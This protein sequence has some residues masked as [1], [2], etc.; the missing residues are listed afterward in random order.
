[1]TL[2]SRR[3]V[4]PPNR[5]GRLVGW[6]PYA[7]YVMARR[8]RSIR[9]VRSSEANH[10]HVYGRVDQVDCAHQY[11]ADEDED[12]AHD[13]LVQSGVQA[14]H[15]ECEQSYQDNVGQSPADLKPKFAAVDLNLPRYAHSDA[16]TIYLR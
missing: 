5:L 14:R 2:F 7:Q 3:V 13:E 9:R 6:V 16:R 1:M 4:F 10:P 15:E 11:D 8:F 12:D